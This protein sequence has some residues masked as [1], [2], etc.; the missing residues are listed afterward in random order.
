ME[1]Y[2]LKD[3]TRIICYVLRVCNHD[4]FK[5]GRGD[6]DTIILVESRHFD[7][8]SFFFFG[9]FLWNEVTTKSERDICLIAENVF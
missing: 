1:I 8:G 7:L 6:I 2:S 5:K 4:H 9:D 3:Q